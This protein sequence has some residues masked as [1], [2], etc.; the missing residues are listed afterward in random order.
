M[1]MMKSVHKLMFITALLS[2]VGLGACSA[3]GNDYSEYHTLPEEGWLYGDTIVFTPDFA[4]SVATGRLV[5]AITHGNDFRF[6]SLVLEV[7]WC[8]GGGQVCRDTVFFPL[9][10]NFGR[11]QGRGLGPH[12]QMA[13]TIGRRVTL[14]RGVPVKVRH[15]MRTDTL[16]ALSRVGIFFIS[17]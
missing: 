8:D 5:T 14:T 17:E 10:D 4:D 1:R 6:S 2:V 11:W 15:I 12:L 7:L 16:M 13:D 9:A 3:P